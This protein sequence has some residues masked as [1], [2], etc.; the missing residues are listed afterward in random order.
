MMEKDV[1]NTRNFLDV[2]CKSIIWYLWE[3]EREK[4]KEKER[5]REIPHYSMSLTLHRKILLKVV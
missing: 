3:R 4:E 1:L 5:E 2:L